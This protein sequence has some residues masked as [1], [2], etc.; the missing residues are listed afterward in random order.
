M[1]E[2]IANDIDEKQRHSVSPDDSLL[3]KSRLNEQQ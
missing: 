2:L 1:I 3:E